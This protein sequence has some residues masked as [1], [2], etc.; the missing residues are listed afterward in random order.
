VS[1]HDTEQE[2]TVIQASRA[3]RLVSQTCQ[4][5]ITHTQ[6]FTDHFTLTA[7]VRLSLD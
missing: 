3:A 4:A 6:R 2:L 7:I 5:R 1:D